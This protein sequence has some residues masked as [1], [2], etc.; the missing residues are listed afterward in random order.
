MID[1]KAYERELARRQQEH[2]ERIEAQRDWNWKPCM[3]DQCPQCVGTGRS[4]FGPCIHSLA[5]DCPK[6]RPTSVTFG[7]P[8]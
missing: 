3:H 5:C 2:L 1:R 8:T 4:L 6:C 7:G